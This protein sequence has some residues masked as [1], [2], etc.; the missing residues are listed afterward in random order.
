MSDGSSGFFNRYDPNR[1]A[2]DRGKGKPNT[3]VI[4]PVVEQ[5]PKENNDFFKR[6][7]DPPPPK[8]TTPPAPVNVEITETITDMSGNV[9]QNVRDPIVVRRDWNNITNVTSHKRYSIPLSR[10]NTSLQNVH[11]QKH[12]WNG[13][14]GWEQ[15][16]CTFGDDLDSRNGNNMTV[17]REGSSSKTGD[18]GCTIGASAQL[19]NWLMNFSTSW[20]WNAGNAANSIGALKIGDSA[21][22]A[23]YLG[24]T[25]NPQKSKAQREREIAEQRFR[26]F[27]NGIRNTPY[28]Q[29]HL[30]P[31]GDIIDWLRVNWLEF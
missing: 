1:R 19:G 9:V 24:F 26:N 13:N 27:Q 14:K 30:N 2:R 28:N 22:T 23:G 20:L 12:K 7:N 21:L 8:T 10:L 4:P 3:V 17:K 25:Y 11:F 29:R 18:W 31:S 6:F 16:T 5:P 15:T